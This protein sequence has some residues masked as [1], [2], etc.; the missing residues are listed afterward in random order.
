M[1]NGTFVLDA[2]QSWIA[3]WQKVGDFFMTPDA[4]GMNYLTRVLFAIGIVVVA[5]FIIKLVEIILKKALKINKKGPAVDKSA[6]FF[7]VT[8]LK[9]L[10]WVLVA[11]LVVNVLKIDMTGA[12][13]ILSAIAV[14][15]GLALQDLIGSLFSG[16]LLIQQKTIL[17]GEYISVSNAYGK[18]EGSVDKVA[19]F[20]TYLVTPQGQQVVIP[21]KNM[22]NAAITNFTRLG[23][24]RV[25]YDVG[26]AFDSDIAL[27]KKLL[28]ELLNDERVLQDE[29]KTVYVAELGE[30]S[31]KIRLRC[32]TKPEDYWPYWNELSEK[33]LLKFREN[34]VYIP[35]ST[36]LT[37]KNEK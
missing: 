29:T 23:R 17:Y 28:E 27:A 22:V 14:A 10:L 2:Y 24:R 20:F 26:V 25:D 1:K 36:D 3:F 37:V 21:N 9:A 6:K 35:C 7:V 5:W 30:Y 12:A 18:S 31:V 19:L 15:L 13:G 8:V 11:F 32:F 16:M 34:G 4:S 33:V